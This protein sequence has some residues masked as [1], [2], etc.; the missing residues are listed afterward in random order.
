M[1]DWIWSDLHLNHDN[2]ILYE[3]RPF[4]STKEMN[5]KIL[6]NWMNTVK[7]HDRIYNLGDFIFNNG[8][9]D[10][11]RSIVKSMPGYKVL[12]MGNHDRSKS[13]RWWVEAGFN[14]VY[15]YPVIID[16]YYILS[17]EP[18]YVGK[19]M[20]YANIHGHWH[21]E[22]AGSPQKANVCVEKINYTPILL[23]NVKKSIITASRSV[24]S[25]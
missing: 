13:V 22:L 12:V 1:S 10:A 6:N 14:E 11:V 16:D 9:K 23:S 17:H 5:R 8:N 7:K 24:N 18:V 3:S 25:R 4:K 19:E 2:I 21:G 20:P 15:K